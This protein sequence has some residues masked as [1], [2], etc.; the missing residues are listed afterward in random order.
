MRVGFDAKR[1]FHNQ[2]GLGNYSRDL[3]DTL[4]QQYP[5]T[6]FLLLDKPNLYNL[7]QQNGKQYTNNAGLLWRLHGILNDIKQL[8]LDVFHGLSNELPYGKWPSNTQKVVTIHDVIYQLFPKQYGFIDRTIYH[9]KTKHAIAIADTIIA[10]SKATAKDIISLYQ[11]DEK[12]VKVVYQ[13]CGKAH[14]Q[15]YTEQQILNFKQQNNLD[16]PFL[17]YVSSFQQRKNHLTLIR[18]F[19]LLKYKNIK[20]VLAGRK[21]DTFNAC[22]KLIEELKLQHQILLLTDVESAELPL[23]YRSAK[24]F[25][26]PSM[27]EGFGIPLLEAACAGLPLAVNDI[28]VFREIAPP[29]TLY[30]N[31][32]DITSITN[33]LQNLI[34]INML[35]D[36]SQYLEK[37]TALNQAKQMNNIYERTRKHS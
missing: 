12:K 5:E 9:Q 16:F 11:A 23:L 29:N 19:S 3:V 14:W 32:G 15:S 24:G 22:K 21:G 28:P 34:D 31:L 18:A 4:I 17:L 7:Y 27:V 8:K 1:Y 13:T 20:L 36:N 30:F 2:S 26:Y 35:Q 6:K 10:T 33:A 37:F 25:V